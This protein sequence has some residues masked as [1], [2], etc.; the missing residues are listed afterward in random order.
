[1]K[2]FVP[3]TRLQYS[4]VNDYFYVNSE[5]TLLRTEQ[6]CVAWCV[7]WCRSSCGPVLMQLYL[8]LSLSPLQI[9][10]VLNRCRFEI[11]KQDIFKIFG[12]VVNF[13]AFWRRIMAFYFVL[14]I[15]TVGTCMSG[16]GCA[17]GN[18]GR[19]FFFPFS[20]STA[21][22]VKNYYYCL[23]NVRGTNFCCCG[24]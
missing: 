14:L 1:M 3:K 22:K 2:Y 17:W 15:Q 8:P 6:A 24:T 20:L 7:A 21:V 9:Q 4:R 5:Q 18:L 13:R 23:Y 11:A 12:Y 16:G 19:S 10:A